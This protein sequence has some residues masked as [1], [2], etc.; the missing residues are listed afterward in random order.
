MSKM[1]R[2]QDVVLPLLRDRQLTVPSRNG[3]LQQVTVNSWIPD[4]DKR[5]LPLVYV[6]RSGGTRYSGG[7]DLLAFPVIE[8]TVFTRE[9]LIKTEQLYEDAL[10]ALFLAVQNQTQ[11]EAGYLH[12]I[13]EPMGATQTGSPFQDSWAVFGRIQLGL[14]PPRTQ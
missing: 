4:I 6:R 8:M 5:H 3:A 11:T 13:T 10:E 2:I 9:D 14:R 1:P 12:S 7:Y